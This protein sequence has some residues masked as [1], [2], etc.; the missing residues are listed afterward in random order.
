M[1]LN[2]TKADALIF[3][4]IFNWAER[5]WINLIPMLARYKFKWIIINSES[6]FLKMSKSRLSK[7]RLTCNM[8]SEGLKS[9]LRELRAVISN[10]KEKRL[11]HRVI[12]TRVQPQSTG[13]RLNYTPSIRIWCSRIPRERSSRKSSRGKK[14]KSLMLK[15]NLL[16]ITTNCWARKKTSRFCTTSKRCSQTSLQPNKE[17]CKCSRE[18]SWSKRGSC[19]SWGLY[20]L[21]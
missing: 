11:S 10:Y 17:R 16:S 4:E 19:C 15:R 20:K 8:K 5:Q 7:R 3:P 21:S 9:K 14:M 2:F 18:P 12:N 1:K 13:S 6:K